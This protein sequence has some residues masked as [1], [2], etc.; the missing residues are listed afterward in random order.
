[1]HFNKILSI[2]QHVA[3]HRKRNAFIETKKAMTNYDIT[4]GKIADDATNLVLN[5]YVSGLWKNW[6]EKDGC[7]MYRTVASSKIGK[8]VLS[9]K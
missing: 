9:K 7:V 8:S 1:M 6:R 4:A 2:H 3:A 5:S